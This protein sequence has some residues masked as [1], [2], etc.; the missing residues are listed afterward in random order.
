MTDAGL[1]LL[2]Q[3]SLQLQVLD[4][5]A[6]DHLSGGSIRSICEVSTHYFGVHCV[7]TRI[8]CCKFVLAM[9]VQF[10]FFNNC[11]LGVSACARMQYNYVDNGSRDCHNVK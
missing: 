1:I 8:V 2:T 5:S 3:H 9:I 4:I 10:M 7:Y 6:C 11:Q